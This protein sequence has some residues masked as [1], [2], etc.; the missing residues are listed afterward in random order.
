MNTK[1]LIAIWYTGLAIDAAILIQTRELWGIVFAILVIG[2]LFV[3]SFSIYEKVEQKI[4]IVWVIVPILL[5]IVVFSVSTYLNHAKQVSTKNL[6]LYPKQE[7]LPFYEKQ[8]VNAVAHF[9]LF[10]TLTVS[11]Y[12]GSTWNIRKVQVGLHIIKQNGE[13]TELRIYDLDQSYGLSS[14]HGEPYKN[15]KYSTILGYSLGQ[16]EKFDWHIRSLK[17]TPQGKENE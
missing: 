11:L 1:Q 2:A 7:E 10:N 3:L 14:G 12:N 9:D 4:L 17:G 16:G 5:G 15:T 6:N 8:K 13:K